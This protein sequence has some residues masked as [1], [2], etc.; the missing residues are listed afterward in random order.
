M[1]QVEMSV[2]K[3]D[4]NLVKFQILKQILCKILY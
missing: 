3:T 2:G 4:Y 1:Y